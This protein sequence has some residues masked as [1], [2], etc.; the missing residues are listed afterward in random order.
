MTLKREME[1]ALK[2]IGELVSSRLLLNLL[3]EAVP[4]TSSS[5]QPATT[6][7]PIGFT[8]LSRKC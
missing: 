3:R 5:E 1:K 8:P 4:D 7:Q 2:L 6:M